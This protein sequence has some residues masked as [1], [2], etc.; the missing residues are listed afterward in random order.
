MFCFKRYWL[1]ERPE[2]IGEEAPDATPQAQGVL[3]GHPLT[4]LEETPAILELK[5]ENREL[6]RQLELMRN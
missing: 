6:R 5:S 1:G 2:T 4:P 3:G